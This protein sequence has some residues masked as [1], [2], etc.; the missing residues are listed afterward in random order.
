MHQA[1]SKTKNCLIFPYSTFTTVVH[2]RKYFKKSYNWVFHFTIITWRWILTKLIS[3]V[4]FEWRSIKLSLELFFLKLSGIGVGDGGGGGLV[5]VMSNTCKP[6][7]YSLPGFSVHGIL[8]ARTL[9]WV[10]ISFSRVSF[11]LL[12]R[13]R[14]PCIA[15]R[16]FSDWAMREAHF[17]LWSISL[18]SSDAD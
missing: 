16:S 11:W 15:G 3:E 2:L 5:A 1:G 14:V 4:H 18:E 6:M 8:Q 9:E 17:W 12:N 13:T 7:D 10:A